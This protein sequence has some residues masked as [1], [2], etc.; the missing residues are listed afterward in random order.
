MRLFKNLGKDLF[1]KKAGKGKM[2]VMFY[3]LSILVLALLGGILYNSYFL[4]LSPTTEAL[5]EG[6]TGKPEDSA[7]KSVKAKTYYYD[8]NDFPFASADSSEKP[9]EN[10]YI[11]SVSKLKSAPGKKFEKA[12]EKNVAS[13]REIQDKYAKKQDYTEVDGIVDRLNTKVIMDN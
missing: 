8:D 6:N 10:I 4:I 3:L 5:I 1:G 2:G 13:V 7:S 12:H 9:L 11:T